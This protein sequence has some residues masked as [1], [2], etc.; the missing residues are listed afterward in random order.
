MQLQDFRELVQNDELFVRDG[1][2]TIISSLVVKFLAGPFTDGAE[3]SG[4]W[5]AVVRD[6][7]GFVLNYNISDLAV[8]PP[9]PVQG[10]TWVRRSDQRQRYVAGVTDTF[11]IIKGSE[12]THNSRAFV[13]ELPGFLAGYRKLR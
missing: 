11:V 8:K 9:M 2:G 13:I 4:K 5:I 12:G 10:E 6:A 3:G 7:Y 1:G